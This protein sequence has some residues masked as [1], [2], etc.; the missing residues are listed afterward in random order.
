MGGGINKQFTIKG[1]VTIITHI[2]RRGRERPTYFRW[3]ANEMDK[4]KNSGR[5]TP[6][7]NKLVINDTKYEDSSEYHCDSYFRDKLK[8]HESVILL[9]HSKLVN[10]ALGKGFAVGCSVGHSVACLVGIELGGQLGIQ[11]FRWIFV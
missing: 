3:R 9:V 7:S 4:I 10:N 8:D 5:M 6:V 1:K 11:L 2:V